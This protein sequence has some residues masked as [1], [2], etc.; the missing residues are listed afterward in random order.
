MSERLRNQGRL[1]EIQ[2]KI[3]DACMRLEHLRDSLR[4]ELDQFEPMENLRGEVIQGLA[5]DFAARQV[6]YQE[7]LDVEADLRRALGR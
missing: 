7:L 2:V 4:L 1:T 6:D 5:F 3:K